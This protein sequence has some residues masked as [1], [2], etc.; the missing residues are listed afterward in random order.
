MRGDQGFAMQLCHMLE[1]MCFVL[2]PKARQA[3]ISAVDQEISR[4]ETRSGVIISDAAGMVKEMT[5][6]ESELCADG[7]GRVRENAE[8]KGKGR[9]KDGKPVV[10]CCGCGRS[11]H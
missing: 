8:K 4:C 9:G 2:V 10:V 1:L 5:M 6:S 11:V 3:R 7:R